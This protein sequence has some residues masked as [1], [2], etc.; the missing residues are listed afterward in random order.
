MQVTMQAARVSKQ[1][2]PV[3]LGWTQTSKQVN[4]EATRYLKVRV[5]DMD[6]KWKMLSTRL[7]FDVVLNAS[8][9]VEFLRHAIEIIASYSQHGMKV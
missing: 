3:W 2:V 1:H 9:S 8:E 5:P 4:K 6:F 7:S